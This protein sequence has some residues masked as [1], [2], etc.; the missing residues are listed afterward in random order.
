MVSNRHDVDAMF[1]T[2]IDHGVWKTF[3]DNH[4]ELASKR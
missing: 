3:D 2:S 1:I 4:A